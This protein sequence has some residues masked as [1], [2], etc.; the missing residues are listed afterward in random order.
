VTAI[1]FTS[2][3]PNKVDVAGDTMTGDLILAGAGTDL[4]VGGNVTVSGILTDGYQGLTGDVSKLLSTVLSTGITS[5]GIITVNPNNISV[6]ISAT[7]GFVYDYNPHGAVAPAN[8]TITYVTFPGQV[9]VVPGS[10]T[11]TF[12]LINSAGALVQQTTP[13]TSTQL[14][15]HLCV[16]ISGFRGGIIPNTT[17]LATMTSQPG[18]Q[19]FD[20][21]AALGSFKIDR[22]VISPNGVNLSINTTGGPVF[23]AGFGYPAYQ[24]PNVTSLAAQIPATFRRASATTILAPLQTTVDVANFD[25]NGAGVITP[26]GGGANTST[27]TRVFAYGA[28]VVTDQITLQ[29][30]QTSFASLAA[31]IAA[32]GRGGYIINPLLSGAVLLAYVCATRTAVNLSDP[33]Q[34]AIIPAAKFPIP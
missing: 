27:I 19:L 5:G 7:T 13:P 24:A 34:A 12:W 33:T 32:V 16:G 21:F 11:I 8:P 3:D 29:Y 26:V 17:Q 2:G 30:G 20:L 22:N 9:G 15:T 23:I 14:R 6:D 28:P 25:P 18:T 1:G 10:P 31:A 4:T